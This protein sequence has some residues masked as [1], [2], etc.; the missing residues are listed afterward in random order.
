MTPTHLRPH[1][2]DGLRRAGLTPMLLDEAACSG[3]W[4]TDEHVIDIC[5]GCTRLTHQG[6]QHMLPAAVMTPDGWFCKERRAGGHGCTV[7]KSSDAVHPADFGGCART[8]LAHARDYRGG[9][10]A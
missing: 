9:A 8:P 2:L 7:P 1:E 5:G 3:C 4:Q 10:A 6:P